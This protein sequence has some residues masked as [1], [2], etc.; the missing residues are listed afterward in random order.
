MKEW[1]K[2]F[3]SAKPTEKPSV[4]NIADNARRA[5]ER[6]KFP[7]DLWI[8]LSRAGRDWRDLDGATQFAAGMAVGWA[9]HEESVK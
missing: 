6:I 8:E 5:E 7:H 1:T 3:L 4:E 9:E 2:K